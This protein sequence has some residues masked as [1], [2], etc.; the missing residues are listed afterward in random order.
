MP[1]LRLVLRLGLGLVLRPG[2]LN[3]RVPERRNARMPEWV[4]VGSGVGIGSGVGSG[5]GIGV[6]SGSGS[7]SG[8]GSAGCRLSTTN[9][10]RG[11]QYLERFSVYQPPTPMA[12]LC[13]WQRSTRPGKSFQVRPAGGLVA[14]VHSVGR[15]VSP[16]TTSE[17]T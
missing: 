9:Y 3:A 8:V 16:G 2:P 17:P 15:P 4:G 7:G 11:R 14:P 5:V 12:A 10:R 13:F 1:R 6:G